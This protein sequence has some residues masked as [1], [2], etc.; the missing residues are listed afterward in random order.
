MGPNPALAARVLVPV[1][2]VATLAVIASGFGARFGVWRHRHRFHILRWGAYAA[3]AI[4]VLALASAIVMTMDTR[5]RIV[6][7]VA[8]VVAADRGCGAARVDAARARAAAD[9]RHHDRHARSAGV[10]GDPVA[11]PGIDGPVRL[12]RQGDG[13]CAARCLSDIASVVLAD[14]PEAAFA[15][16][17]A[18]ARAA[19]W[20][21]IGVR[22]GRGTDRGDGDH[23]RG[24]A[25][26]TTS[27]CAS[28]PDGRGSRVDVRSVSRIGR[29]DLG[30][31]ANR[32]REFTAAVAAASR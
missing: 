18:E 8:C 9:Q 2:A 19:G 22:R 29:G 1:A 4:A 15:K 32:V 13:R 30:A 16:A 24:S 23:G 5:P 17:L 28:A 6:L 25:S 26:A 7:M 31:N 11:A 10:R 20:T 27:S 3:L 14:P 21:I 12:S